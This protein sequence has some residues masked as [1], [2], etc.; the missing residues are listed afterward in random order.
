M[1]G[2]GRA[3]QRNVKLTCGVHVSWTCK[4]RRRAR[5]TPHTPAVESCVRCQSRSKDVYPLRPGHGP[6]QQQSCRRCH[7][8][9]ARTTPPRPRDRAASLRAAAAAASSVRRPAATATAAGGVH[10]GLAQLQRGT[11]RTRRRLCLTHC[12]RATA[13]FAARGG[14]SWKAHTNRHR[15]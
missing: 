3:R 7:A 2:A 5:L 13:G 1:Y 9:A 10:G 14:G 12:L 8:A 4:R 15:T 6:T 11:Q